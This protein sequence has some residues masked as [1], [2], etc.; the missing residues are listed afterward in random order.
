MMI[1]APGLDIFQSD[2]MKVSNITQW[3]KRAFYHNFGRYSNGIPL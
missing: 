2:D 3:L 1:P